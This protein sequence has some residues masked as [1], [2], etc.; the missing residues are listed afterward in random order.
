MSV[1]QTVSNLGAGTSVGG[2]LG[3]FAVVE[4]YLKFG[5]A[6]LTAVAVITT[7]LVNIKNLRKK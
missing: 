6:A 7:I 3:F 4:P 1:Q 5:L 2:L